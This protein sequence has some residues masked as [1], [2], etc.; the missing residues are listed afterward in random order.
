MSTLIVILCVVGFIAFVVG[1][2]GTGDAKEGA[3]AGMA[4]MGGCAMMMVQLAIMAACVLA[5]FWVLGKLF[6]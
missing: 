6:G 4:A 3:A 5:G 2:V 1:S